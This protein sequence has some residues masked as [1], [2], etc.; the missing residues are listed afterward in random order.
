M[1]RIPT[2]AVLLAVGACSDL[3]EPITGPTD[4]PSAAAPTMQLPT[5]QRGVVV[6]RFRPGAAPA[7]IAGV[8]G[9]TVSRT[10]RGGTSILRV[11][12]G[13]EQS[14]VAALARNPNVL[15]AELS[16]PRLLGI[17]C[18]A[19]D[20]DCTAPSDQFFGRRWDLHNDGAVRDGAGNVLEDEGLVPDADMDWLEA[21]ERLGS[22]TGGATVGVVD[23]G[24]LPSHEDLS[25]RLLAQH[26]F[27][28]I[29]L[30]AEDDHGHGTHVSGIALAHA[31]NGKGAA[32]IAYGPNVRLAM[33]KGCGDTPIG[34]ICWSPDIADGIMWLV[35]QGAD[36]INLSLGGQQPSS[37]EQAA[38]QY[39]VA[40]DVLPVC[41]AGN[42]HAAVDWPAAFPECF[43]VSATNWS[44]H[45]ASYSSA[46]PE[47]DVSAPGG[48]TI[49]AISYDMIMSTF[50]NGGYRYMAGTSMAAPQVTGLAALLHALGVTSA[51][52]K[53]DVIRTSA[54]DLG[55]PGFD[56][57][58][59]QGR[60]NVR[61]AV[62][63]VL[64][65]PPPPPPTNEPPAASFTAA[66]AH[67]DCSFTDTS[68]DDA[69]VTSWQ[70]DFGDG[71]T[72]PQGSPTHSY[73][74]AGTFTVTLVATDAGALADTATQQVTVTEPPPPPPNEPPVASF[75]VSCN[76]LS[77]SFTDTSTDDLGV[78]AWLWDFGDGA[79]S[80]LQHP[81]H[82]YAAAGTYAIGLLVEDADNELD[83]AI[84]EITVVGPP[85]LSATKLKQ[86]QNIVDLT[87]SGTTQPVDLYRNNRRIATAVPP[88]SY[89]DYTGTRGRPT[90]VYRA[91][92][93]G[94]SIC[95]AN[96]VV[97]F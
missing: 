94:T 86:G 8:H 41:A 65:P 97:A 61:A 37:V 48:D 64:G 19:P 2:I 52:Q 47:V 27:F 57:V 62:E 42:D 45:R 1:R 88:P 70:W 58:Y 83:L 73:A 36:V 53:R 60:I 15:F 18:A 9:A 4:I 95:S 89:R 20:G 84:D 50:N 59:G 11:T 34:Y 76:G 90:F 82:V 33:A 69:G 14:V 5:F 46:G 81:T 13:R 44:D 66:C 32:G 23:T 75:T 3:G 43:A 28:N 29:D 56:W 87:W 71:A 93:T 16:V 26:D 39:A 40:H 79:I 55:A 21:F 77:C 85:V 51:A 91:C 31:H 24:I 78:V 72:S 74:A 30:I 96:L 68:T 17:P 63:A 22:F 35:D 25:G 12:A 49:H 67:L 92:I 54:D 38:L 6:V 80:D 7:Q 10:L